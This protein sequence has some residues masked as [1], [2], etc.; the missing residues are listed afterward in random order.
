MEAE[1]ECWDPV[2]DSLNP[3][4]P[5]PAPPTPRLHTHTDTRAPP[6]NSLLIILRRYFHY[7]TLCMFKK[8][9][10]FISLGNRVATILGKKL[11]ALLASVHFVAA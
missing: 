6:S 2:K 5:T 11:P 4:P 10:Q 8:I 9:I 3:P 1:S 7:G